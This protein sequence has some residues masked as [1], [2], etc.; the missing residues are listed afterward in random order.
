[1]LLHSFVG[2][3]LLL[4]PRRPEGEGLHLPG[5]RPSRCTDAASIRCVSKSRA[6]AEWCAA[7]C[8]GQQTVVGTKSFWRLGAGVGGPQATR[9]MVWAT[10]HDFERCLLLLYAL[11]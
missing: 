3:A 5:Q 2:A 11:V 9:H 8:R 4:L 6:P 1:M 7:S 10:L